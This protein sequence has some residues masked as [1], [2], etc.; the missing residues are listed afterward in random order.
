MPVYRSYTTTRGKNM[1]GAR[2]LWRATGMND[3]D[4]K[5]PIIAVVNSFT[6]FVPGHIHLQNVG[7]LVSSEIKKNRGCS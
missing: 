5:K 6:E 4:F 3:N 7:K 1:S 2:A